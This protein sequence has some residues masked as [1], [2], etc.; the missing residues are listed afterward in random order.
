MPRSPSNNHSNEVPPRLMIAAPHGR[1]GKTTVSIG[2]CAALRQRGLFVQPFKKGPDYIDPSWLSAAANISC[3]N[4]DPFFMDE[5]QLVNSFHQASRR[6]DLVLIEG[7]MGLYDSLGSDGRGSSAWVARLLRVPIILVINTAR[8]TRSVAAMVVGYQHFEP[9]SAV[10]GVIFNNVS[11]TRHE[12]KLATAVEDYC[13][14]PVLGAVPR[15]PAL[16]I[17]ER[18]LGLIPF[19]EREEA[20]SVVERIHSRLNG[21]LDL[22]GILTVARNA[23]VIP[24]ASLG[25]NTKRASIVKVGVMLDRV[26]TF[27]Y[28]E[29]L[30]ALQQ[31]GAELVFIDSLRDHRLPEID[32]LYI[33]GGFPEF[34]LEELEANDSLRYDIA[35]AAE[36]GLPIYAECAGLMYLCR[37]IGWRGQRFKMVGFIPTEVEMCPHPQAHGYSEVEVATENPLFPVGSILRGHEFHHSR[38]SKLDGL[39]FAYRMQRGRGINGKVDAIVHKNAIASFTHLHALG[40]P[41]WAEAFVSLALRKKKDEASLL[42]IRGAK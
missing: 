8:M 13:G 31:A 25:G 40:V 9:D 14:I 18:H 42:K 12:S 41:Q 7:A 36:D 27:Y 19:K 28:P 22:E 34:F 15:D 6:A 38:L 37:C 21:H 17:P 32:A 26:F 20:V 39:K 33:G 4:L 3:R 23:Q 10:A 29:N 11:G 16:L 30:E 5:G 2:L 35:K 1:S 24:L